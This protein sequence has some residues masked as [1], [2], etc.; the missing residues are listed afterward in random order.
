MN[1]LP[2]SPLTLPGLSIQIN[3]HASHVTHAVNAHRGT[4]PAIV[5]EAGLVYDMCRARTDRVIAL[6]REGAA[7]WPSS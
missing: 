2:F 6:I 3:D 7:A 4:D 5:A 1:R